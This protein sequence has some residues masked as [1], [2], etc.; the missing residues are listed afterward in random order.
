MRTIVT[1]LTANAPATDAL[2]AGVLPR[3]VR[4]CLIIALAPLLLVAAYLFAVR[5]SAI[6]FDLR[7]A[8]GAL[9][10]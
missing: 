4:V 2:D 9:C 5:G 3:R 6:L 10:F 7:D 1:T 8:V